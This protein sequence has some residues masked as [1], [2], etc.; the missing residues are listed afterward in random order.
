VHGKNLNRVQI[1]AGL[2]T[3]GDN[4]YG[5]CALV[6]LRQHR[7]VGRCPPGCCQIA[8]S[9][10]SRGPLWSDSLD[11]RKPGGSRVL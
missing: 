3:A 11:Q 2:P 10:C 7:G 9:R 5:L 1:T 6:S 8:S 4:L